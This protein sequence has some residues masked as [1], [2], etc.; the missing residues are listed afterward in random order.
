M[1][2]PKCKYE[3]NP[4]ITVCA[5]CDEKLVT[6]AELLKIVEDEEKVSSETIVS[7]LRGLGYLQAFE[8]VS[9]QPKDIE[10]VQIARLNSQQM[11][12][13]LLEVLHAKDLAA[14]IHSGAGYFGIT[15]QLGMSS[16]RP[17]GGGYSLFVDK[18]S[19]TDVDNEARIIMGDEWEKCK[20]VDFDTE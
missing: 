20:L 19:L 15:G 14:V 4:E 12:D 6:E 13:M 9:A 3:Y 11:S 18:N 10:W 17:I 2:C 16:Y 1:F 8:N 7:E 5:D